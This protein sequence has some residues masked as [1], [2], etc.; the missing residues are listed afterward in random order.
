MARGVAGVVASAPDT[1]RCS[2]ST[3]VSCDFVARL[4]TDMLLSPSP[5]STDSLPGDDTQ[6]EANGADHDDEN[7]RSSPCLHVPVVVR[8]D[9]VAID[10][11]RKR[12]DRPQQ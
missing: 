3:A 4:V 2:V 1:D 8:R 9:G 10:L 6:E 5:L 12:A 11:E 7:E